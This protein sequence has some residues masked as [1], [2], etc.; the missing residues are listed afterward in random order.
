[1]TVLVT[2]AT[3]FLGSHVTEL[4]LE[5]RVCVRVLARPGTDTAHLAR[6]GAD[7]ARGDL[8]DRASLEAAVDG[9][10]RVLHCAARTGPWGPIDVYVRANVRGLSNLVEAALAA[11]V[12][13]IVH[14]SSAIVHGSDVRGAADETAPLREEP[15][16]YSRSKIAGE[17]LLRQLIEARAAP[18]TIVRPGLVYGPRDLANSARFATLILRGRMVVIG[19][20]DNHL[21]LV[22][23]RDAAQGI[24]LASEVPQASGKT[25]LLVNDEPVTQRDYLYAIAAKLGA[26]RPI[27]HIP[28]ELA[29]RLAAMAELVGQVARRTPPLTRFGVRLLGGESL[30]SISRARQELGFTPEVSMAEGVHRSVAWYKAT[31]CAPRARGDTTCR[32]SSPAPQA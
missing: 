5:R 25:Y 27:R 9:V 2:G 1:M 17:L 16:P 7:V 8:D 14:V 32:S 20:G 21:P 22:Y 6:A 31:N 3:G 13:R 26:P 15:N 12:Q 28:Y 24:L 23:A 18:V 4:L 29:Q 19:S 30:F 11:G 10:D